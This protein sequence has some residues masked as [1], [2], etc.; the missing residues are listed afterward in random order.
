MKKKTKKGNKYKNN[1]SLAILNNLENKRVYSYSWDLGID[2]MVNELSLINNNSLQHVYF[3]GGGG[4]DGLTGF[5]FALEVIKRLKLLDTCKWVFT[6]LSGC[7]NNTKKWTDKNNK[8]VLEWYQSYLMKGKKNG[9]I[10][11]SHKTDNFIKDCCGDNELYLLEA[12][13]YTS[14]NQSYKLL[15][16]LE[17]H[18]RQMFKR[19]KMLGGVV[20][21]T[22]WDSMMFMKDY[23]T[24]DVQDDAFIMETMNYLHKITSDK[25]YF[26][27]FIQSNCDMEPQHYFPK[28]MRE[29]VLNFSTYNGISDYSI[30]ILDVW[31]EVI[32]KII[33]NDK[34]KEEPTYI[35]VIRNIIINSNGNFRCNVFL[36][37]LMNIYYCN[38]Y[39][40]ILL[41][42]KKK[43]INL[44]IDDKISKKH[45]K[46]Y[47]LKNPKYILDIKN[48]KIIF[49][50]LKNQFDE[51]RE[52]IYNN[53]LNGENNDW[54]YWLGSWISYRFDNNCY[55]LNLIKP[56]NEVLF[57]KFINL[58]TN[59]YVMIY[60]I[61]KLSLKYGNRLKKNKKTSADFFS[62]IFK[63]L[64][65]ISTNKNC[66]PLIFHS[67]LQRSSQLTT[68]ICS[69][70]LYG[71]NGFNNNIRKLLRDANI[72][73][74]IVDL[75]INNCYKILYHYFDLKNER[76][77][78]KNYHIDMKNIVE[79]NNSKD[80][81]VN[82]SYLKKEI[83]YGIIGLE[84]NI[85]CYLYYYYFY[86]LII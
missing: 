75:K 47:G 41:K 70:S 48:I 28:E 81:I 65:L 58:L 4:A 39:P 36:T 57:K 21:E 9:N 8:T 24:C 31:K 85:S 46:T 69:I 1:N 14:E 23:Y 29:S 67:M 38:L 76:I 13:F 62:N 50:K 80:L 59:Q 61:H 19:C 51:H 18:H 72:D 11:C 74:K 73:L 30:F 10:I 32:E 7:N 35:T 25:D 15:N 34:K 63:K 54:N 2:K 42:I 43:N 53:F 6:C 55:K 64:N 44:G 3:Y 40:S 78:I 56:N 27:Y 77:N 66:S 17:K 71:W 84:K 86:E 12:N 22:G 37:A 60:V 79:I 82:D 26:T 20:V 16:I 5:S 33:S 45:P 68:F 52:T 83:P 49:S